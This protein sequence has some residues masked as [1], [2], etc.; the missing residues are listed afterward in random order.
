MTEQSAFTY[1]VERRIPPGQWEIIADG[2]PNTNYTDSSVEPD[3]EYQYRVTARN[4]AGYGP[5]SEVLT[6]TTAASDSGP[7][8]EGNEEDRIKNLEIR[9]SA[10]DNRVSGAE[11]KIDGLRADLASRRDDPLQLPPEGYKRD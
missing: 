3:T 1:R 8:E 9:L 6:V 5:P 4:S 10:L 2:L 7:D 11:N